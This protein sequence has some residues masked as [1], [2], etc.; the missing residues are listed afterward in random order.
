MIDAHELDVAFVAETHLHNDYVTGG[1]ELARRTGAAYL[2]SADDD[3]EFTRRAVR[4]GDAIDVGDLCLQVIATPG[5]T[6]H[7]LAYAV[8]NPSGP[9]AVFTG[10]SLLYGSVGRTDLLGTE[11]AEELARL[12][13]RSAHRLA[14]VLGDEVDVFPTHGFGS[15]C[16]A[17]SATITKNATIG[18]E[19]SRNIAL[20]IEDEDAFVDRVLS[21]YDVYPAYYARMAPLNRRGPGAARLG[22]IRIVDRDELRERVRSGEWVVDLR[23]RLVYVRVAPVWNAELPTREFLLHLHRLVDPRDRTDH[24]DRAERIRGPS[25]ATTARAYRH[26]RPCGGHDRVD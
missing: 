19:R 1:Y 14:E 16:S 12:Q 26:R 23:E 20:T 17:G 24:A 7:H 13:Y 10:G 2:V 9:G 22:S 21:A 8:T 15:F 3:V 18:D 6:F 5:H 25:G 11:H 4:D